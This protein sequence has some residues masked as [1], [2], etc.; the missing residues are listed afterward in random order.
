MVVFCQ[1]VKC[2]LGIRDYVWYATPAL[3]KMSITFYLHVQPMTTYEPDTRHFSLTPHPHPQWHLFF[4]R[5]KLT[6]WAGILGN[7]IIIEGLF[8]TLDQFLF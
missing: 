1:V 8:C 6:L 2:F 4:P 5:I 3:Q 7:A